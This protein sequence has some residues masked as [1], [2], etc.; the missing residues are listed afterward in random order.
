VFLETDTAFI[1][2]G[3]TAG[4]APL[5]DPSLTRVKVK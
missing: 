5:P 2:F 1:L 3:T 4:S